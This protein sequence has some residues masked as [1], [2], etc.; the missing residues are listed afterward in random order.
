MDSINAQQPDL[1]CFTGDWVTTG[2]SEANP[3]IDILR[4]LHATDGVVSVLGNYDMLIYTHLS[5][6]RCL[7]EVEHLADYERT[8]LG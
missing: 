1:I 4:Q 3:Y 5:E 7:A 6:Q 2:V 8:Q